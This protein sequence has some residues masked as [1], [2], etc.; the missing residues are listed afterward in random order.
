MDMRKVKAIEAANKRRILTVCADVPDRSGI[1]FLLRE[2]DG[3]RYAYIGQAKRLLTRL[4]QHLNGYQHIDLSIKK[5][6]LYSEDNPVGWHVHFL[7][8]PEDVLD[9]M[10][11]RYIKKYANAGY[12]LRNKTSGSQGVG[13]KDLDDSQSPKGYHDGLEQG[14]KNARRFVAHLFKLHLDYRQKSERP[15]KNQ[16]KAAAKFREFLEVDGDE[17]TEDLRE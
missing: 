12:Q 10:E 3:F 2:E 15:N 16:E 6:G 11:Q 8:F 4:A 17:Q 7:E 5:H 1:Y 13:K 14:Y 9:E